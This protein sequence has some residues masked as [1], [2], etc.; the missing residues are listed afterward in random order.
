VQFCNTNSLSLDLSVVVEYCLGYGNILKNH[1]KLQQSIEIECHHL[2]SDF[3]HYMSL[4][5][6]YIPR[7]RYQVRDLEMA[8]CVFWNTRCLAIFILVLM[9]KH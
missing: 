8:L 9:A 4:M 2:L 3:F 5:P 1:E 7:V 6:E